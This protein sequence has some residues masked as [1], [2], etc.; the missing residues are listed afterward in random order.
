MKRIVNEIKFKPGQEVW[1]RE[2]DGDQEVSGVGKY[3]FLSAIGRYAI[4]SDT[5]NADGG[6]EGLL[7][8]H[9]RETCINLNSELVVVFLSDCFASS[10]IAQDACCK[11]LEG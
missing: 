3:R 9:R 4:L 10:H 2:R 1:V 11:D 8:Y 5:V 6:L 7:D